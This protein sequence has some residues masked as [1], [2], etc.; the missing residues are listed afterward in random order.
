VQIDGAISFLRKVA[1]Y[2]PHEIDF[3]AMEDEEIRSDPAFLDELRRA[4]AD[5]ETS[6]VLNRD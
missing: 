5:K 4:L 6:R 1:Q 2:N 3:D